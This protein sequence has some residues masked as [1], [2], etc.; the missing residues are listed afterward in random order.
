MEIHIIDAKKKR[1]PDHK[2]VKQ[3]LVWNPRLGL[4]PRDT[5]LDS[6]RLLVLTLDKQVAGGIDRP[7]CI[8]GSAGEASAVFCKCFTYHQPGT[9]IL[10]AHL[11]ISGAFK[12]VVFSEPHD[13]GV[14]VT[15]DLTLQ[16]HRLPFSHICIPQAL[17]R[18]QQH[19][20]T[21]SKG[22]PLWPTTYE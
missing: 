15:S 10:I 4:T 6:D 2:C 19:S 21:F 20:Q 12:L 16:S 3:G 18:K 8:S 1:A 14:G 11:E 7:G 22:A 13:D 9:S 17:K 5:F